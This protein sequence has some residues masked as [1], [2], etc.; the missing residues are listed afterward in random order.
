MKA[1]QHALRSQPEMRLV[2]L[3][4]VIREKNKDFGDYDKT[5]RTLA[6]QL[7]IADKIEWPGY[8]AGN[9]LSGKLLQADVCVLP[10]ANG[11]RLHNSSFGMLSSHGLPI[12]TTRG[13][14]IESPFIHRVQRTVW[15]SCVLDRDDAATGGRDQKTLRCDSMM[16]ERLRHGALRLAHE[17]YSWD[18]SLRNALSAQLQAN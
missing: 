12:I 13:Q 8:Q 2:M 10:F 16:R 14:D 7:G 17:Y 18:N 15:A 4:S 5:L 9:V 6:H 11:V 1:F 3:G